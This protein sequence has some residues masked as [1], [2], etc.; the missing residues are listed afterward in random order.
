[1]YWDAPLLLGWWLALFGLYI[2]SDG[3]CGL[4]L[5]RVLNPG[6]RLRFRQTR[7]PFNDLRGTVLSV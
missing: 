7:Q 1:M 5:I 6:C 3:F 4:F 2:N